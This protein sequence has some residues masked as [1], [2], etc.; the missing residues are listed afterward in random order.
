MNSVCLS[1]GFNT[2]FILFIIH[3]YCKCFLVIT[4]Y[5]FISFSWHHHIIPYSRK[6][7]QGETLGTLAKWMSFPNILP[8]KL[9]IHWKWFNVKGL[10]YCKF[11]N[12]FLAKTLKWL[13]HQGFLT[14]TTEKKHVLTHH[15]SLI[16]VTVWAKTPLVRTC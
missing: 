12:V 13:I 11:A 10:R 6:L 16:F 5:W 14:R 9:Q 1:C 7:W 15:H 3:H 8:A 4:P 2:L